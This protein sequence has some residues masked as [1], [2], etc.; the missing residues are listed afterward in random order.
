MCVSLSWP[1]WFRLL[2]ARVYQLGGVHSGAAVSSTIW[3][4][5]VTIQVTKEH[6][7]RDEVGEVFPL[8]VLVNHGFLLL[9]L[10]GDC[11]RHL[12]HP[13]L[14]SW[15]CCICASLLSKQKSQYV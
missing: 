10:R 4:A 2:T 13:T 15:D 7:R 8:F 6:I 5:A 14:S 3:L 9:D 1:L 11:S 12:G